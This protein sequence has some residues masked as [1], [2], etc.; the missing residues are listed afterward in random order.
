VIKLIQDYDIDAIVER[1]KSP[2]VVLRSHQD[3]NN[4]D[5]AKKFKFRWSPDFKI[6]WKPVKEM[7]IEGLVAQCPFDVSRVGKEIPIDVLLDS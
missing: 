5:D 6:W 3:R 4:N 1:A 2:V 7:D